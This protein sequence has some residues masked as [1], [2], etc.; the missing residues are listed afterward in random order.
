MS[1]TCLFN[2]N[3]CNQVCHKYVSWTSLNDGTTESEA[4]FVVE[5]ICAYSIKMYDP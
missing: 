5:G 4:R 3:D 1:Y 2:N